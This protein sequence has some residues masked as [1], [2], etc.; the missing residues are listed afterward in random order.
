M[1]NNSPSNLECNGV[2]YSFIIPNIN[3]KVYVLLQG[4][5]KVYSLKVY[6]NLNIDNCLGEYHHTNMLLKIP[7]VK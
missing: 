4:T 6:I 3:Y 5:K 1:G 2:Y 7:I